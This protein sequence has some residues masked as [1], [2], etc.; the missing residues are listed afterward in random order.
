MRPGTAETHYTVLALLTED[1][2]NKAV[3]ERQQE[4]TITVGVVIASPDAKYKVISS[5]PGVEFF[6]GCGDLSDGEKEAFPGEESYKKISSANKLLRQ[7]LIGLVG[8]ETREELEQQELAIRMMPM[9]EVDRI[10]P[11]NAIQA[12]LQTMPKE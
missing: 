7:A 12:L 4:K 3:R 11:I 10:A 5:I 1:W 6:T 2:L 9:P 8:C